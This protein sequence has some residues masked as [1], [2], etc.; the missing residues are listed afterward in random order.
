[1]ADSNSGNF[2]LKRLNTLKVEGESLDIFSLY[3]LGGSTRYWASM[4]DFPSCYRKV[5]ALD[6]LGFGKV[7]AGV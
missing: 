4:M 6:L 7:M 3:G 1:M 2:H 5:V